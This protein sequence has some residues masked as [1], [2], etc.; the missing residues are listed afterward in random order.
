[1][2]IDGDEI[3]LDPGEALALGAYPQLII[4]LADVALG[5][6]Y[7]PVERTRALWAEMLEILDVD[8]QF[9]WM[10]DASDGET[11]NA[12]IS[13]YMHDIQVVKRV[14]LDAFKYEL[15]EKP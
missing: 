4:N 7:C 6:V 15:R 14:A 12:I 5:G 8:A 10:C 3:H 9:G 13:S 2:R 1:M 11:A